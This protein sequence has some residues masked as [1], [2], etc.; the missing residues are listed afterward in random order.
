M[1]SQERAR[2]QLVR[3]VFNEISEV[4]PAL[5]A[6]LIELRCGNDSD[7]RGNI[8][9]LLALHDATDLALDNPVVASTEQYRQAAEAAMAAA[10]SVE[11]QPRHANGTLIAGRYRITCFLARSGMGEVY[12]AVDQMESRDVALKFVRH[13]LV[14]QSQP[15]GQS[16]METRFLREVHMAQ[17]IDHPNVCHIYDLA[18]HNGERF[19][20]M[21]LLRG[22]TLSA[23]LAR[24]GKYR[25]A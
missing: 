17:K 14:G 15:V 16:Q 19:C 6:T 20:A 9:E 7:L 10:K 24:D 4:E 8:E 18:E 25:P 12:Q 23:K 1:S 13:L 5:R 3:E 2:W 22:E 11:P 21:E